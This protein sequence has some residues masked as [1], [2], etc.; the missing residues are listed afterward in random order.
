MER[1]ERRLR[2]P[3]TLPRVLPTALAAAAAVTAPQPASAFGREEK[4]L[5]RPSSGTP[6]GIGLGYPGTGTT[7]RGLQAPTKSSRC[8]NSHNSRFSSNA[9]RPPPTA[10]PGRS[11]PAASTPSAGLR[12]GGESGKRPRG[13]PPASRTEKRLRPPSPPGERRQDKLAR[14]ASHSEGLFREDRRLAGSRGLTLLEDRAVGRGSAA[15]YAVRID[16]FLLWMA[17]HN[18]LHSLEAEAMDL[19]LIE[20]FGELFWQGETVDAGSKLLATV[21]HRFSRFTRFGDAHL[22]RAR[23]ALQGWSKLVPPRTRQPA[24]WHAVCAV[25]GA[26]LFQGD[27]EDALVILL[28]FH[29]YLRPGELAELRAKSLLPPV[30]SMGA[31]YHHWAVVIRPLEDGVPG[32][33][34]VFDAT[35]AIGEP[36]LSFVDQRLRERHQKKQPEDAMW[37]LPLARLAEVFKAAQV[38]AGVASLCVVLYSLGHGGASWGALNRA[39]ALLDIKQR[40]RWRSDQSLRR[41]EKAARSQAEMPKL[42]REVQDYGRL[43]EKNLAASS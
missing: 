37:E 38:W 2:P 42:P 20:Y 22:P 9:A 30:G 19:N 4:R 27:D 24:P 33:T 16:A 6:I 3:G 12:T 25:M 1:V 26:V 32:K 5:V 13:A 34:G 15:D 8:D 29:L 43:I 40:G 21:A 18:I 7:S 36:K 41:Y 23:R 39:R 35:L 11:V 28:A 31:P 17:T 14:R 10:P